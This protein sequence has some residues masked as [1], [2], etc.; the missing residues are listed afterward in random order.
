MRLESQA[1]IVGLKPS[2]DK[3]GAY[4]IA[5]QYCEQIIQRGKYADWTYDHY[6]RNGS[7]KPIWNPEERRDASLV[8][9]LKVRLLSPESKS[10][11]VEGSS[12]GILDVDLNP[13]WSKARDMEKM[14]RY[15]PIVDS[16]KKLLKM[17]FLLSFNDI[18]PWLRF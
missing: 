7:F 1:I 14:M 10:A 12:V 8:D 2:K 5:V 17:T 16:E 4:R 6:G 18:F 13:L 3:F 9:V 15:T 11:S